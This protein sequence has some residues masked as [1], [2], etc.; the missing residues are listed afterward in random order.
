[1]ASSSVG[2]TGGKWVGL[3]AVSRQRDDGEP[4]G[5][6]L[7]G[8]TPYHIRLLCDNPWDG[9]GGYTPK[10]VGNMTLDQIFM[11]LVDRKSLR[12]D[13]GGIRTARMAPGNATRLADDDGKA[14]G[15]AA[16]GTPMLQ[17][18]NNTI[19]VVGQSD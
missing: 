2:A 13:D 19:H 6:L 12:R 3:A 7:Y 11:R 10:E 5:G 4:A 8:L 14:K 1:M 16:D 9:G 17:W 18:I 15:R